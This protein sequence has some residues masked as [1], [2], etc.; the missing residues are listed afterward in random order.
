M[1]IKLIFMIFVEPFN[2]KIDYKGIGVIIKSQLLPLNSNT[3]ELIR[4]LQLIS[5][6]FP[7]PFGLLLLNKSKPIEMKLLNIA[8]YVHIYPQVL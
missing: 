2:A 4:N 7:S 6:Y 5:S 1:L 3:W 8:H